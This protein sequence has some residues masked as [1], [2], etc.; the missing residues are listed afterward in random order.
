MKSFFACILNNIERLKKVN[1]PIIIA[2]TSDEETSF[3][4]VKV[5]TDYLNTK[6]IVPMLTIIGE[7]T[8]SSACTSSKSCYEYCVNIEGKSC[9]SSNP[10]EG[11]N[12]NYIGARLMI[13][14]E[15]LCNKYENTTLSSNVVTGGEKVN[16]VANKSNL[17]FD[18]R[19]NQQIN[20]D[21]ALKDINDKINELKKLYAGC[22]ITLV[23]SLSILPYEKKD[24]LILKKIINKFNLK[25]KE[26]I[27]GCEAGYYQRL[28]GDAIIFGCGDLALAHKPNEYAE[29]KEFLNYNNL[30]I[31]VIEY[32]SNYIQ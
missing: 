22:N 30:L 6:N 14:I 16:V 4:G 9:H 2:I 32:I 8:S 25:E 28:G 1:K 26:F 7:P 11:I 24:S 5:L 31:N 17:F 19:S 29:I 27:G 3:E 10:N 15:E 18:I 13:Y 21:N 23:N 12:A 20:V